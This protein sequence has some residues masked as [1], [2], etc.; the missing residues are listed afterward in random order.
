MRYFVHLTT[1]TEGNTVYFVA[2][3]FKKAPRDQQQYQ[4]CVLYILS[5]L[6]LKSEEDV[7]NYFYDYVD[8]DYIEELTDNGPV[9]V[10]VD[11]Q[12][13]QEAVIIAFFENQ[14][15]L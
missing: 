3:K 15:A 5:H 7:Q 10:V 13:P 6:I 2:D 4:P 12:N 8:E 1:T 9:D 14:L 11:A